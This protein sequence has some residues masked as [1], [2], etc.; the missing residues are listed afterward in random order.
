MM[1]YPAPPAMATA[2]ATPPVQRLTPEQSRLVEDNLNLARSA[3]WRWHKRTGMEY[4]DLQS[5]AFLG[6]VKACRKFDPGLGFKIS[7]YAVPTIR[8]ELLHYVRD[9]SYMLRLSH[10]MRE[11]WVKGR[12]LLDQGGSDQEIA[13]GLGIPLAEW[14]DTRTACS[15]PPLELKDHA[16]SG[17]ATGP[18]E[19]EE[20][21]RLEGLE[22]AADEAWQQIGRNRRRALTQ[23]FRSGATTPGPVAAAFVTLIAQLYAERSVDTSEKKERAGC[24]A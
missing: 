23:F 13:E 21:D 19:A 20:D 16:E 14:L 2:T 22:A 5:A 1:V 12:R 15:G 10:R 4:S 11:T 17:P 3:A 24:S 8:G 18:L 7:T 6:L 9:H